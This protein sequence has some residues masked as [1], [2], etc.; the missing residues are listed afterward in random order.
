[1][2]S[3]DQLYEEIAYIAYHFKWSYTELMSMDHQERR[4]WCEEIRKINEQL[5]RASE[6]QGVPLDAL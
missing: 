6:N 2:Y 1:M 3:T 5:N 4:R